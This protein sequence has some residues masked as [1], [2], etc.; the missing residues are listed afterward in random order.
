MSAARALWVADLLVVAALAVTTQIQ[1]WS[2]AADPQ[3]GT[4][5]H[6]ALAALITLPLLLRRRYPVAVIATVTLAASIQFQL[7][8]DLAQPWF[9]LLLAIYALGAHAELPLAAIGLV[10]VAAALLIVDLPRLL[11]GAPAD[12]VA[13]I[14][15]TVALAWVAGRWVRGRRRESA[16]LRHAAA[17]L[18]LEREARAAAAVADERAR[19]ARELHDLV[20]H[21]MSVINLQAQGARRV[22]DEDPAAAAQALAAIEAASREGLDEMRRLLAVLRTSD[23]RSDLRPQPGLGQLAP[24]VA[25]VREAGLDVSLNV[26]GDPRPLPPGVEL[27][28]FRVV[29]EALTNALKH[30]R[31]GR[32]QVRLRYRAAEVE[33]EIDNQ[34]EL[35]VAAPNPAA[36]VDREGPGHGLIG[37]RERVSLYG[38]AFEAGR[39]PGGAFVVRARLPAPEAST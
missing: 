33:I 20:A 39:R 38:G 17:R 11:A 9:A 26:E 3:G 1:V 24:L 2:N 25:Q 15:A 6:A 16:D 28:A 12:E 35:G 13:P 22:L 34:T 32:A 23:D 5:V 8:G 29:Q 19:I 7:G 36:E 14:W 27:A 10:P 37:M 4:V 30:G 31:P 18:E 21:S